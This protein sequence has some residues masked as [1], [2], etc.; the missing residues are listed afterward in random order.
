MADVNTLSLD[1]VPV[2]QR[3]QYFKFLIQNKV[4]FDHD[5]TGNYVATVRI[6]NSPDGDKQSTRG[7]N[8]A[9]KAT[10]SSANKIRKKVKIFDK[11]KSEDRETLRKNLFKTKFVN[12][13]PGRSKSPLQTT[14]ETPIL[15]N[16]E[17]HL[18]NKTP[19]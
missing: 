7:P 10:K 2:R 19:R 8:S 5:E 17:K 9:R 1:D 13:S 4:E 14:T 18:I 15:L 11:L 3:Y 12:K 16:V 6:Q